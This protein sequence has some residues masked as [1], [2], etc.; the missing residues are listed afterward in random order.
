MDASNSLRPLAYRLAGY[1]LLGL[2]GLALVKQTSCTAPAPG[3]L[4]EKPHPWGGFRRNAPAYLV[5]PLRRSAKVAR[6]SSG[7]VINNHKP[8]AR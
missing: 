7:R 2:L 5:Y 1:L 4:N 3:Y 8:A 6:D